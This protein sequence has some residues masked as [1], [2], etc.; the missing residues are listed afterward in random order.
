MQ[1][2]QA[3]IAMLKDDWILNDSRYNFYKNQVISSN[4]TVFNVYKIKLFLLII[5]HE[6]WIKKTS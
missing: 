3:W 4:N 1:K 2:I 5:W 6:R